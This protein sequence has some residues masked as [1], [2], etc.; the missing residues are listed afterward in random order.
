MLNLTVILKQKVNGGHRADLLGSGFAGAALFQ[1]QNSD[2]PRL[3]CS[4]HIWMGLC[5]LNFGFAC[6]IFFL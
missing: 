3:C 2:G 4:L 6:F 1:Y 5:W